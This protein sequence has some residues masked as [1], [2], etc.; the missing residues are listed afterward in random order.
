MDDG[1]FLACELF[2]FFRATI[3]ICLFAGQ[4]RHRGFVHFC[5]ARYYFGILFGPCFSSFFLMHDQFQKSVTVALRAASEASMAGRELKSEDLNQVLSEFSQVHSA[6]ES[7]SFDDVPDLS[8]LISSSVSKIRDCEVDIRWHQRKEAL[9]IG[10]TIE[11]RIA[12]QNIFQRLCN[13]IDLFPASNRIQISADTKPRSK[14]IKQ[15][16]E[17]FIEPA[18]SLLFSN[19]FKHYDFLLSKIFLSLPG[20]TSLDPIIASEKLVELTLHNSRVQITDSDVYSDVQSA[21]QTT[22]TVVTDAI[23][24]QVPEIVLNSQPVKPKSSGGIVPPSQSMCFSA[25]LCFLSCIHVSMH[26]VA[27]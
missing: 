17:S 10:Y 11:A 22:T 6:S 3:P 2:S 13:A 20:S 19:L 1:I 16:P 5:P 9:F 8:E 15:P 21:D 4:C 23:S 12:C 18:T 14:I 24:T 26:L 25:V 27:F 7:T